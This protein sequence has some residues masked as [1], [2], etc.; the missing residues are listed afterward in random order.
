MIKN[1]SQYQ[2][3]RAVE[4]EDLIIIGQPSLWNKIQDYFIRKLTNQDIFKIKYKGKLIDNRLINIYSKEES[5]S[6]VEKNLIAMVYQRKDARIHVNKP[7]RLMGNINYIMVENGKEGVQFEFNTVKTLIDE[8]ERKYKD[9]IEN[10]SLIDYMEVKHSIVKEYKYNNYKYEFLNGFHLDIAICKNVKNSKYRVIE[11]SF[12]LQTDEFNT[13]NEA[14]EQLSDL[15]ETRI[16]LA[17]NNKLIHFKDVCRR[18]RIGEDSSLE[19]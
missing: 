3:D 7:V 6:N 14:F 16:D 4:N 8:I 9:L 11:S 13:D 12:G 5:H 17:L 10:T 18:E 19:I 1:P 15:L 2:L